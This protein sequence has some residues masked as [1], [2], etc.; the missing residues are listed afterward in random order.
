M[1]V[2]KDLQCT[3]TPK[4][5]LMLEHV[6]WQI[7]NMQGGYW[8]EHLHQTGKHQCLRYYTVQNPVACS[9]DREKVNSRN[10]HPDV[11]V[12]TEKNNEVNKQNLSESHADLVGTLQKG[13]AISGI[14]RQCNISCRTS[15]RDSPDWPHYS[16]MGRWICTAVRTLKFH[17]IL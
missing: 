5:H 16:T 2:T 15:P 11:I 7:R 1:K 3:V 17:V 14:S 12:Q 9:L 4:V 6:E 13:S 10:M 8:V